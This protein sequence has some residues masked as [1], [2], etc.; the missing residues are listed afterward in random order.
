MR[1]LLYQFTPI[2]WVSLSFFAV[3]ARAQ[4]F[5]LLH[6]PYLQEVGTEAA[7]VVYET[8]DKAFTWI[9]VK[10]HGASDD[11][12]RRCYTSRDGLREAFNAFGSVRVKELK[13]ACSY[14]YRIVSKQMKDFQPYKVTFGDSIA[15]PWHTFSTIN[16]QKKG[17]TIFITSDIHGDADKLEK[18]LNLADY[19]SCDAFFY[20]GDMMSHIH[21]HEAPFKAFIDSSVELFASSI[22]F[23]VV[24]GNHETR[25]NM[26]RS[27]SQYFPKADGKIYGSYLLG[28]VMLI[29]LDSGEDKAETHWVYAGLTDFNAYRTE[30]AEWL[31][32]LVKSKEYRKARYH[33][34]IGHFPM[35]MDTIWKEEKQWYGWEDAIRKFLPILN[36]AK[37]DLMVSGHTHRF[38]YHE[39]GADGNRFP[40]L[41][42][43]YNSATRLELHNGTIRLKVID[44][45]GNVLKD[46]TL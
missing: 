28:D 8:S 19:K 32:Q 35:V 21:S 10:P 26:A 39:P 15:T 42:Q 45:K 31:K 11:E 27:Y 37:V 41:E 36:D 9:E 23:E 43:G 16:P 38:H 5:T 6:G 7:T 29:M 40:V 33:I 24:R 46:T 44:E 14:D 17:S 3:S 4:Q 13:P 20:A 18:L 22:P 25:G 2:L 12:A 30:Q 34:V 1:N